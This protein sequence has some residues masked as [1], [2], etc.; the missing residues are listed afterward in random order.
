MDPDAVA[1]T[2]DDEFWEWLAEHTWID[3]DEHATQLGDQTY[4]TPHAAALVKGHGD[5]APWTSFTA[6]HRSGVIEVGLGDLGSWER[7]DRDGAPT[8][9]FNLT[10]VVAKTWALLRFGRLLHD[11]SGI[12][13][14]VQLVV[15][16]QETAGALLGNL[17]EGWAEPG[18]F[19]NRMSPCV[20]SRLRWRLEFDEC[21]D[22]DAQRAIAYSIGDRLEDAWG[23]RQRRYLAHRG[24]FTGRLDPRRIAT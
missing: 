8:A 4:P 22:G 1:L 24:E 19:S 12:Q 17:G 7:R 9:V 5:A 23:V 11:R 18:D 13:G 14:P 2:F 10:T 21:P 15:D 3:L 16:L 20:E 6:V